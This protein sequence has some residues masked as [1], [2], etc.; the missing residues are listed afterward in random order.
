M[1][2]SVAV[3]MAGMT[4]EDL[5]PRASKIPLSDRRVAADVIDLIIGDT[6]R[7]TGCVG[8]M[9]CDSEHRG[10][11]PLVLH[12]IPADAEA[13]GLAQLLKLVLPLVRENDGS[14][15]IGRGRPRGRVPD[16]V[17]RAW[18]QR[19]IDLC[20]EAGVPLLGFYLATGDGVFRLPEPLTAAS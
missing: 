13:S 4:F 8:L 16:D 1:E 3:T 12:D 11:Q 17:D 18:H 6:D 9:I 10:L 2:P 15:L 7:A 5:P 19:T 20:E 14:V